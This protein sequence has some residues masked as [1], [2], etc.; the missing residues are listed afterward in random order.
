MKV[1]GADLGFLK[2]V[3]AVNPTRLSSLQ[4]FPLPSLSD[5]G[6]HPSADAAVS[7]YEL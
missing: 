2:V 4:A 5:M 1:G 7:L 6:L 3:K